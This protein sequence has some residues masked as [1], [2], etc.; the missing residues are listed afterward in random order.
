MPLLTSSPRFGCD[1]IG[2]KEDVVP[3][4]QVEDL[5]TTMKDS[6]EQ[7]EELCIEVGSVADDTY[8]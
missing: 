4:M 6:S 1:V 5:K 7:R 2:N 3:G 8:V